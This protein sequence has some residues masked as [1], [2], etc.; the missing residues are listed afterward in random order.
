[1]IRVSH[2]ASLL[3]IAVSCLWP[4][5]LAA[6]QQK[7]T[8]AGTITDS[9]GGVLKGAQISLEPVG[10]SLV[11][12]VQGQ[13]FINDLNPGSYTVTITYV[14]FAPFTKSVDVAA[15]QTANVEAKLEVQSQS[16]Q[17]LVTAERPSAEA[18]SV[19]QE[20]TADNIV[21]VLPA[22]VIRSLPNANMA[23]ALGRLPSVTL[24]RD[25]GEGKYVQVRGTAPQLTN[26]TIDGMSVPSPEKGVRQIKFDAI[27]ADIVE[28]VEINKTLQAN[29]DADGIG[30][31]VNLVTK[32]AGERPT[33]TFGEVG[34]YTPIV[35]GR[36]DTE[37]TGTIGQRFGAQKRLGL[38]IGGSYDWN[39]RGIDDIEP[40]SDVATFPNG[41]TALWKDSQDIREYRYYRSRWALTGSADY[42]I[43]ADSNIYLRGLYSEFKNYGDRWVYS[44]TDNT[45][46][47]NSLT[48]SQ[49]PNA[50]TLFGSNGCSIDQGTGV[51][52]CGSPATFNTQSRRPDYG[53]GSIVIGGK[54]VL[55][56]TW[57]SWDLSV[58]RSHETDRGYGTANFGSSL[59]T[60]SCQFAPSLTTN[61]F[62]PQWSPACFTEAYNPAN[63]SLNNIQSNLGQSAQVNLQAAASMA[64]RYHIG[65]HLS[66]IEI[67]GKFRNAHKYDDTYT[68]KLTP[69]VPVPFTTFPS[70]LTNN[71]YYMNAYQLGPNPGYQ[72]VLAFANTTPIFGIN[73]TRGNDPGNY[74]LVEKVGA[75]YLMD[76]LDVSSRVRIVAGV[77]FENTDL[78]TLTFDTTTGTLTDRAS[79]SYL[80]TLPSASLRYGLTTNNAF[81]FVYSRGLSRP[82]YQDLAQAVSFT[83]VG[84]P[85]SVKNTASLGN[86]N[87]K[88]ETAD[89]FDILFEHY[90]NSFG[91]VSAGVFYKR[92]TDP[93]VTTQVVLTNFQ[94][95][96]VAPVGTYTTTTPINAGD[97]AI[98]GFEAAYLERLTF[99]PGKLAG[100]GISAN[101]GYTTS[102]VSGLPGRADHPRLLRNAPNTW[103]ISPTYD[104][105]RY[106]VRVGLS[107]NQ[108]NISSYN[109]TDGTNGSTPIPGGLRGPFGDVYFYSHIQLDAQGSVRFSHGLE[110]IAYGLNLTNE[111]FGFYQGSPQFMI[112][113]E[114]YQ[115]TVAAGIR[116]SPLRE[117]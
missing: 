8:I 61:S 70:V 44:L 114:F 17:V 86:P 87:L 73:S 105:G 101:Y 53:I 68:D 4:V 59:P 34:G 5:G 60:S 24:E 20:R 41:A 54:H 42:K 40:V 113:R 63:L 39:G 30:G 57:F 55:T 96:P 77:R 31:S 46:I 32:T 67:G 18:E 74:N 48:P 115:P 7:G 47:F 35:N 23:D 72:D 78:T 43:G 103:N 16:L 66:T 29:M 92:I 13:F 36:G 102:R 38:L 52:S 80:K 109:Y 90:L 37:A 98:G 93:I 56:T 15:N 89:N 82:Q 1:V 21:Q 12:D 11:S 91:M 9:S 116:W 95:S 104:R 112:Q 50:P 6:Q 19:N 64:K 58:G 81:R 3:A 28:A 69:N 45:P 88:A 71:H 51:E 26:T 33:M 100:L 2:L 27:P 94:P 83:T 76:T 85:G 79:G 65:S 14:G 117:K 110:F 22:E 107:Y 25:E 10:A 84:S 62:E 108:A 75:G 97:A 111:V 49:F 106:S 99:L